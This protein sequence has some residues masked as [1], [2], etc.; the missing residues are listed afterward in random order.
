MESTGE[1]SGLK[2]NQRLNFNNRLLT[3]LEN[4]PPFEL[5]APQESME[6]LSK[7][8][9]EAAKKWLWHHYA[10]QLDAT[11]Q[12]KL[13]TLAYLPV[14]IRRQIWDHLLR[15]Q[16]AQHRY[17]R[18]T[19][20]RLKNRRQLLISHA[21]WSD[22]SQ[23]RDS[24]HHDVIEIRQEAY[25][26]RPW[27]YPIRA[28]SSTIRDECDVIL[29]SSRI[30]RFECPNTMGKFFSHLSTYQQTR[31][32]HIRV[33]L[34]AE[35]NC[36]FP[37]RGEHPNGWLASFTSLPPNLRTMVI[38][39]GK[40]DD[41]IVVARERRMP[42]FGSIRQT[43]AAQSMSLAKRLV[44]LDMLINRARRCVPRLDVFMG[45]WHWEYLYPGKQELFESLFREHGS[46]AI[47]EQAR[48][49]SSLSGT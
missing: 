11:D 9:K 7:V 12:T 14:E 47:D 44:L 19:N 43:K 26:S 5:D 31:L 30:L 45:T 17:T 3:Y 37:H 21:R 8:L 34:F 25:L 40:T 13:G 28:V 33:N 42:V 39:T 38:E 6:A 16:S 23:A 10:A 49:A 4:S 27:L 46:Q 20:P 32:F 1:S 35:C 48:K 18:Y 24:L 29:F 41:S 2:E 22:D 36:D 15:Y